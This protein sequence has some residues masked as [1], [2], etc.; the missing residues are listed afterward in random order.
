MRV[1]I[2]GAGGQVGHDLCTVLSGVIPPGGASTSLLGGAPVSAGEFDVIAADRS[3]LDVT[4]REAVSSFVASCSPEVIVH[5][6]AYTAVDRAEADPEGARRGNEVATANVSASA[7][8]TGA[9]LIAISTDYVFA[10]DLGRALDERDATNPL[11]VYG[12]TKL[13]GELACT[14]GATIVRTSWVA[15]AAGR[16]VLNLAAD[17]ATSGRELAFVDD[18]VGSLTNA[19]DLAAGLVY[20]IRNQPGGLVHVAGT[21]SAS[22]F[23]VIAHAVEAAGGSRA[24]VRAISTAQLDPPPAATRP[25]YSPLISVRS[26]ELGFRPLPEWQDGVSRLVG[27]LVS[28]GTR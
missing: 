1:L 25:A 26:A 5:L 9:H 28:K 12:A 16:T 11:S 20:F 17:A 22:W 2:T 21:G 4:D 7:D 24:Q 18:Q 13:A 23:E 27:A 8:A 6:A 15:G 3:M 14:S 19:A 10:G